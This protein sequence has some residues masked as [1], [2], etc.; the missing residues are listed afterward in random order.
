MMIG[1]Q[2]LKRMLIDLGLCENIEIPA[3]ALALP[4]VYQMY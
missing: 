3:I 2:M 4:H 1:N